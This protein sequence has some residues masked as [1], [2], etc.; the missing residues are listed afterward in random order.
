MP[1]VVVAEVVRSGF[2][3]SRHWGSAVAVDSDSAVIWSV[4]DVAGPVFPRSSNKPLQAVAM[5]GA[6]LVLRGRL[7]ALACASHSGEPFHLEGVREM[8][9]TGGLDESALQTPPDWPLDETAR[10]AAIRSGADPSALAMNC[11]GKHAAMLLTCAVN[12]WELDSYRDFSAPV[13]RAIS[14]TFEQLT[15]EAVAAVGVDGCGAPLLATSLTGLARA[16][17]RLRLAPAGTA[18]HAVADAITGFPTYVSGSR[19]D[20][21]LLLQAMPG[22]IA[23]VGAEGSYALA[24]PD[25]VAVALKI[26]DGAAR[27]RHVVLA[28]ILRLL[29]HDHPVLEQVAAAPVLGHGLPVGE[30]RAV[31][32]R[33]IPG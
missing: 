24:L 30:I 29:G 26:A 32:S 6:G 9:A 3:E 10:I 27:A 22:V 11:S 7:L 33:Q 5:V 25:G 8:L 16:F 12:G 15:G 13:Q 31:V 14:T 23:K 20:E 17:S 18:E 21:A 19:R 28:Q 4:G 2:V 1:D